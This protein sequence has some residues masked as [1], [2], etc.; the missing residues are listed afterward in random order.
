MLRAVALVSVLA[1]VA[2]AALPGNYDSLTAAQKTEVLWQQAS[3]APYASLPNENPGVLSMASM[4][5]PTFL[6]GSFTAATDEFGP[7]DRTKLIH[8]Y[9]AVAKVRFE[10]NPDSPFTGIFK[11][12]GVGLARLSLAKYDL[13]AFTPGM[14]LKVLIDG[15]NPSL[16]IISMFSLDGQGNNKNFFENNFWNII[17]G[18]TSLPLKLL[19]KAFALSLRLIPGGESERPISEEN[20]PLQKHAEIES[21][22]NVETRPRAP[23]GIVFKPNKAIGWSSQTPFDFRTHLA[24]VPVGSPLYTI[25]VRGTPDGPEQTIG[26]LVADSQFVASQYGDSELFFQHH[27]RRWKPSN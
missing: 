19:A 15:P 7:A 24:D 23:Y 22:G 14:A 6:V 17:N 20:L 18:P 3:A 4:F 2:Q 27:G 16:N 1:V 13:N 12:G 9:G 11:S 21:N 5:L 10:M 25:A 26:Q 8:T